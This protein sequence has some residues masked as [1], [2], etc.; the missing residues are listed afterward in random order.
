MLRKC[1]CTIPSTSQS[2]SYVSR[3]AFYQSLAAPLRPAPFSHPSGLP[4]CCPAHDNNDIPSLRCLRSP[5]CP[6][7]RLPATPAFYAQQQPQSLEPVI[8]TQQGEVDHSVQA[9]PPVYNNL[10]ASLQLAH[11]PSFATSE[12][13]LYLH[14]HRLVAS[15][16]IVHTVLFVYIAHRVL[17]LVRCVLLLVLHVVHSL[18]VLCVCCLVHLFV[19]HRFYFLRLCVL[20]HASIACSIIILF[21]AYLLPVYLSIH[22]LM[23]HVHP[24]AFVPHVVYLVFV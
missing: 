14:I 24:V 12:P 18:L 23:Q 19:I 4:C 15:H 20:V 6:I 13:R 9:T 11:A 5:E 22:L 7:G 1:A 10:P 2:R 8:F 16:I 17:S 3:D 21:Y